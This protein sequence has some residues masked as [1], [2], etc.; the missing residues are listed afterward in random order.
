MRNRF[1][2]EYG[3]DSSTHLPSFD[4]FIC[5][6][7]D[8]CRRQDNVPSPSPA[9]A[10]A[11]PRPPPVRAERRP[12]QRV[13]NVVA[14]RQPDNCCSYCRA[15]G[16]GVVYCYKFLALRFQ[17]RRNIVRQRRWCYGC[18]GSHLVSQCSSSAAASAAALTISK[19][20]E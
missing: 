4:D 11:R 8:E 1:E 10:P 17:A 19:S 9:P 20:Q 15:P 2:Q 18:L 16:H 13:Y 6:L 5:F 14:A 7:E 3:G 12:D